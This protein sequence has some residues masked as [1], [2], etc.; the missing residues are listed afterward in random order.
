MQPEK[1]NKKLVKLIAYMLGRSPG[2]FGLVP[3]EEGFVKTKEFLKAL[4][5]ETGGRN[6]TPALLNELK[7]TVPEA[8]FE[9]K[10]EFIR[11]RDRRHLSSP[12]PVDEIP[13]LLYTCIRQKALVHVNRRGISPT[14]Q[15]MVV[16]SATREMAQRIGQRRDANP[17]TLTIHTENARKQG[18][19][20]WEADHSLFL[21]DFIPADCF[22]G[23]PLPK[24][25]PA[26]R[27]PSKKKPR[28]AAES[29][30]NQA[31]SFSL[32]EEPKKK[33]SRKQDKKQEP[34]W[35][36]E[37]KKIRKNKQKGWPD[38]P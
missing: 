23:P 17:A 33:K 12:E 19:L 10:E 29:T 21:A 22:T 37:R 18:V 2:E 20:F 36:K 14:H 38:L 26:D 27:Q 13:S 8:P 1:T 24:E 34:A 11:A 6:A 28:P 3:S 35:K 4:N 9:I 31:G 32:K 15:D 7:L 5:E 25:K 16:M 30:G